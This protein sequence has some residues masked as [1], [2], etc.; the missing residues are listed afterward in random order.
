MFRNSPLLSHHQ[1]NENGEDEAITKEP[2]GEHG[3]NVKINIFC[4]F[5]FITF[6]LKMNSERKVSATFPFF[7]CDDK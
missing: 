7:H 3:K 5:P 2:R 4:H 6:P 1:H